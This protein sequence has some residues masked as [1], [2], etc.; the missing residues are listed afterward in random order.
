M[1]EF[2]IIAGLLL[3]TILTLI[4][5]TLVVSRKLH[6][7]GKKSALDTTSENYALLKIRKILEE[8][9]DEML[10]ANVAEHCDE[11]KDS[12]KKM[13]KVAQQYVIREI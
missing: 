12:V 5:S 8:I 10:A 13:E 1:S 4:L 7:F 9:R 3:V 11:M 2:Q 6:S